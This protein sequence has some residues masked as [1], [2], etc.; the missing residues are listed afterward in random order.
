MQYEKSIGQGIQKV[1]KESEGKIHIDLKK[2]NELQFQNAGVTQVENSEMC[3]ACDY[4]DWFS[5]RKGNG[6]TG[7][8]GAFIKIAAA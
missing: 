8:F 6:K 1:T 3:T 7:R 2:C 4:E 5:H